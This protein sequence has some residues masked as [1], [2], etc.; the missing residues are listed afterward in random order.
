MLSTHQKPFRVKFITVISPLLLLGVSTNGLAHDQW[1]SSG[2][3]LSI[4]YRFDSYGVLDNTTGYGAFDDLGLTR[5][6][7]N[8]DIGGG[9]FDQN[10][11]YLKRKFNIENVVY[12]PFNRSKLH[13]E[14]VLNQAKDHP[15]DTA[16]SMSV[17][18]VIN[19]KPARLAHIKLM[20]DCICAGGTA[21]FKVYRGNGSGKEW[22]GQHKYQGNR[23]AE[24]YLDEVKEVFGEKNTIL[25]KEQNLIIAQKHG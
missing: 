12:D 10:S 19:T 5:N 4:G 24:T 7:R 11:K 2:T 16:T 17:L 9:K 18:N 14:K 8:I 22:Y 6:S 13:N 1:N 20:Y 23:G 25:K 15:F 3:N 21:Y